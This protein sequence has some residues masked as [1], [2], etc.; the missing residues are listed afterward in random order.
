MLR[1]LFLE[2]ISDGKPKNFLNNRTIF[3]SRD[4]LSPVYNMASSDLKKILI[5]TILCTHKGVSENVWP[6]I[7]YGQHVF[8]DFIGSFYIMLLCRQKYA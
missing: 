4:K 1:G 3:D 6:V 8:D 2:D 7:L 5:L